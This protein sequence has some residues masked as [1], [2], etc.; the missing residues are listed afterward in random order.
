[1][2]LELAELHDSPR[3]VE[4]AEARFLVTGEV[5]CLPARDLARRFPVPRMAALR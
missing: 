1:M 4:C 3:K 2:S 5:G